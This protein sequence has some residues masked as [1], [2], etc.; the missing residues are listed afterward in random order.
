MR[1]LVWLSLSVLATSCAINM[2]NVRKALSPRASSDLSCKASS[3]DFEEVKQTL[4]AP[5]VLVKGC[6]KSQEYEL[7][8]SQWK[9]AKAT[10]EAAPAF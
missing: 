3:L 9:P 6:G 4:S 7:V 1:R 2:D 5:R 8:Q 10:A